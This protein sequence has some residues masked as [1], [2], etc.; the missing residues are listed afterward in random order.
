MYICKNNKE[1]FIN[2]ENYKPLVY[3]ILHNTNSKV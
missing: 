3:V 1:V 2:L